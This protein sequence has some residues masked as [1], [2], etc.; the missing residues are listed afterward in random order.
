MMSNRDFLE[1][2]N[3]AAKQQVKKVIDVKWAYRW[4]VFRRL[5]ELEIDCQCSTNEPLLV[6]LDSPITLVQ[7]WSV[8]RQLSAKQPQLVDWLNE[9]WNVKYDH[10]L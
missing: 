2:P 7:I 6:N 10:H 8:M 5:K 9:C 4:E 3:S 1:Q